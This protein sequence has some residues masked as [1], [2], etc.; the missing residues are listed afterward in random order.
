MNLTKDLFKKTA[1]NIPSI[2][3]LMGY[4]GN[5]FNRLFWI[6]EFGFIST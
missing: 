5:R 1:F 4:F 2:L 6:I 3:M